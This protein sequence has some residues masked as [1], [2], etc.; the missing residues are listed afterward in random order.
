[1]LV[2][3]FAA[4]LAGT[5]GAH[6]LQE[7]GAP[8]QP[9]HRG[10]PGLCPCP[11]RALGFGVKLRSGADHEASAVVPADQRSGHAGGVAGQGHVLASHHGGVGWGRDDDGD[12]V[13]VWGEIQPKINS[14]K[15]YDT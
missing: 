3:G 14:T 9:G 2:A 5:L 15:G 4:E 8:A 12:R 10:A 11:G 7:Q 1:M 6:V 13:F